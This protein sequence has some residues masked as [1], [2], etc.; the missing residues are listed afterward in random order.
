MKDFTETYQEGN[1]RL[2]SRPV[3]CAM[4]NIDD[5][6]GSFPL[7]IF[8]LP[9]CFKVFSV[10]NAALPVLACLL[11]LLM[12][13]QFSSFAQ[14]CPTLCDPMN[15]S[16]KT[17]AWVAGRVIF[18]IDRAGRAAVSLAGYSLFGGCSGDG[19]AP[20]FLILWFLPESVAWLLLQG[21]PEVCTALCVLQQRV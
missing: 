2:N 19:E 4:S 12:C 15:R 7:I 20:S 9:L 8:L 1:S 3:S 6:P 18:R 5:S 10:L 11:C 14:S 21:S 17:D 13:Y 16:T